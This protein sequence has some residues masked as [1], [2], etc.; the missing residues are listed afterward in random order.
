M[1]PSFDVILADQVSVVIP[2]LKL[3][4]S[5]KVVF[6]YHFP[7]LLLAQHSTFLRR[8]NFLSVNWF[9]RKKNIELAISAFAMLCSL[10]R[11]V[12]HGHDISDVSLTVVVKSDHDYLV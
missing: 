11:D 1:W 3:K 2:I 12:L 7:D 9:E 6:Y 4:R 5:T 8:F 10:E